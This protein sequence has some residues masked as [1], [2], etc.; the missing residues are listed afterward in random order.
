MNIKT[1][2]N[3]CC[4]SEMKLKLPTTKSSVSRLSLFTFCYIQNYLRLNIFVIFQV[5]T[6]LTEFVRSTTTK[7]RS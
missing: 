1:N 4:V 5:Q 3:D 2:K 7:I 6:I